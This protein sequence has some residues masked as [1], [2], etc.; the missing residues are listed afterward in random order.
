ME[1]TI[2]AVIVLLLL[3]GGGFWF[4]VNLA[5]ENQRWFD[6]IK[7][8]QK[9]GYC[10]DCGKPFSRDNPAAGIVCHECGERQPRI[11]GRVN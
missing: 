9:Y 2:F 7:P 3:F 10:M 11:V 4:T 8:A 1:R 6:E 5:K